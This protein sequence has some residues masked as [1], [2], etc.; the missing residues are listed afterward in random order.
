MAASAE[1]VT[2]SI[3]RFS[4]EI[5]AVPQACR[6][7]S[8]WPRRASGRLNAVAPLI[9]KALRLDLSKQGRTDPEQDGGHAGEHFK[10]GRRPERKPAAERTAQ[11]VDTVA[12]RV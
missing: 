6:W 1:R 12:K 5:E 3:S 9:R 4:V 7:R 8:R 10:I 11:A 2:D